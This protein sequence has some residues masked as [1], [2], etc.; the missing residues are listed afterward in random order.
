VRPIKNQSV[1]IERLTREPMH[2]FFGYYDIQPFSQ[3]LDYH[4]CNE[5]PFCNR[6]QSEHDI[7]RLGMIR[8]Y[9][10][11]FIPFAETTAWNFQQGCMLQWNPAK[12][13]D[14]VIYNVCLDQKY[15]AVIQNVHTGLRHILPRPVATVDP[16]GRYA[17]SINF[18]RVYW[19]RKGY[20]YGELPDPFENELHPSEDGV[21]LMNLQTGENKLILSIDELYHAAAEY[22]TGEEERN[23]WK[24][25]INHITFNT[26][27]TRFVALLRGRGNK[28]GS[29]WR[30]YTF[31]A[32]TDGSESYLLL[33][34][35]ASHYHW[36][37]PNH[38][39]F[40]AK[41]FK[42]HKWGLY[43]FRDKTH[44]FIK[45]DPY[46]TMPTDGHCNFSPDRKYI[47][48][49]T[50]P[51]DGY[52]RLFLY[53][54]DQDKT[55]LLANILSVPTQELPHTDIRCDLHPRWSADGSMI[56]FDSV[57][58]GHRHVYLIRTEDIPL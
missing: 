4:L 18:S 56:S 12:P 7:A 42:E 17:L 33:D 2:Y 8:L 11:Q 28:P 6:M 36:R 30:T 1:P 52:R 23:T 21:F 24:F 54:I 57:H 53:D 13:N 16:L 48:N 38:I 51:I 3:S 9:D 15:K 41:N 29:N 20:G 43:L 31:T 26:D 39:M 37:D 5:V 40:Y 46:D 14:E 58:E 55:I 19:F 35:M 50:Y 47:L 25:A 44:E 22:F 32:N 10:N 45:Y 49:D 34:E 27:G